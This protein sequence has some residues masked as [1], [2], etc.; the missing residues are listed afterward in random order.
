MYHAAADHYDR[1]AL[2]FWERFGRATVEQLHLRAGEHVF[3]ACCGSGAS[4]LA[5][6]EAVGHSGNVIGVDLAGGLIELARAKAA[7]RGL[8]Q[9]EFCTGDAFGTH[10]PAVGFDAVICGFGI[11]FAS[12]MVAATAGLWRAVRPGGQLALS[13]WGPGAFEP[14]NTIFWD[15]VRAVRPELHKEFHP[16]D[17]LT[18]PAAVQQL[19]RDAGIVRAEIEA[20]TG[21]HALERPEDWWTIVLGSGY[22]GTIDLLTAD[23]VERVRAAVLREMSA[24]DI[25]TIEAN[26]VYARARKRVSR[27]PF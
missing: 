23:E 5:A 16:W 4:A 24:R 14:A 2:A 9:A 7:A 26:V 15:A 27:A 8:S 6:A 10:A 11:F 22:R 17:R 21:H 12:D 19:L 25:R 18:N 13:T 1:P 20:V 3:D